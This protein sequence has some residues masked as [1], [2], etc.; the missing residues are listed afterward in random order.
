MKD[1]KTLVQ[2]R[3]S[4]RKFTDEKVTA[5][6]LRLILRAALMSPTSKSQRAWR[7]AVTDDPEALA[8]LAEAKDAG[9]QF[10][11]G[12]PLAIVVMGDPHTNDCW[13]EDGAIA[14]I[15]MQMQAEELGLGTCWVQMRER[16]RKDGTTANTAIHDILQLPEEQ[17]VL[18]VIAIGHAADERKPQDEE[19]LKWENVINKS[20]L[21]L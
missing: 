6:E 15:M 4:H 11:K 20:N 13:I 16:G 2:T 21:P 18:A 14:A 7:F 17:Q 9:G 5:E 8:R 1:F 12:A 19:R 3:R 10:L